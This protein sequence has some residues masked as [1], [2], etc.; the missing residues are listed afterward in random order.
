MEVVRGARTR[1]AR[2]PSALSRELLRNFPK[3]R[4]RR[5]RRRKRK[6]GG[7]GGGGGEANAKAP[8]AKARAPQ[9]KAA[10]DDDQVLAGIAEA[11]AM[12][13]TDP[14]TAE[15]V[16][17]ALRAS[18][19]GAP[20]QDDVPLKRAARAKLDESVADALDDDDDA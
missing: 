8:Q 7:G 18:S 13:D 10:V 5:G 3:G 14:P 20:S 9:A 6:G 15:V 16:D 11:A 12:L 19:N 2:K 17:E 4:G 1:L